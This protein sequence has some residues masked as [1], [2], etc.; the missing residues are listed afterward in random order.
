MVYRYWLEKE[1]TWRAGVMF[2]L[3]HGGVESIL[4]GGL[5]FFAL[6]QAMVF[7]EESLVELVSPDQVE[8][9]QAQIAAYQA[10]PWYAVILGE[11]ERLV[12]ISFHVSASI[13][14][15]Q[16]FR[17]NNLTWLVLAIGWHALLDGV[18]VFSMQAWGIYITESILVVFGGLSVWFVFLLGDKVGGE[19]GIEVL[20]LPAIS[21]AEF[22]FT[23]EELRNS[24]YE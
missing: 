9:A 23:D 7:A 17:R 11:V 5:A 8:L 20:K 16:V 1:R 19:L 2:G 3:G 15:L 6:I 14:V 24:H 21:P 10:M 12:A 22:K 13:L 18:A 4:L